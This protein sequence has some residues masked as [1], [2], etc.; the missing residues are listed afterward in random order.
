MRFVSD[1]FGIDALCSMYKRK[2]MSLFGVFQQAGWF[3][4]GDQ[5]AIYGCEKGLDLGITDVGSWIMNA[6]FWCKRQS[7]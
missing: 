1:T 7:R 2:L 4:G 5:T 6:C 3:T